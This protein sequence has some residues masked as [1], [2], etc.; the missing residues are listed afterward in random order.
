M[1]V[2]DACDRSKLLGPLDAKQPTPR[3]MDIMLQDVSAEDLR[4]GI[5]QELGVGYLQSAE[6]VVLSKGSVRHVSGILYGTNDRVMVALPVQKTAKCIHVIFVVD[7]GS[8]FTFLCRDA[9]T[10]L[11]FEEFTPESTKVT[12]GGIPGIHVELSPPHL[13]FADVNVLGASFLRRTRAGLRIAYADEG[14][15]TLSY[16][17]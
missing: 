6:P 8:P 3:K 5:A 16:S 13:H 10:A 17:H 12:L 7:T 4:A 14:S 2:E 1:A 15:V 9:L 11:G